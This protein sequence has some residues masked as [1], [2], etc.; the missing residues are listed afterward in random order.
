MSQIELTEA[1]QCL[2]DAGKV[3]M[4]GKHSEEIPES[5]RNMI[6]RGF[7]GNFGNKGLACTML[8]D[9]GIVL[10]ITEGDVSREVLRHEFIHAAQCHA[11]P[12]TMKSA[13]DAAIQVGQLL[14]SAIRA[15]LTAN[16]ECEKGHR[17]LAMA[18]QQWKM[19]ADGSATVAAFPVFQ[20]Y[21]DLYPTNETAELAS[22]ILGFDYP[23]G[24]YAAMTACLAA[25]CG[26]EIDPMSDLAR[27]LVA[28]TFEH[29]EHEII[30]ELMAEAG[31]SPDTQL[32]M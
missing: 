24:A 22:E 23:R 1:Q 13:L 9:D 2:V 28:Y 5:E 10:I 21:Q 27:E 25:E 17:D 11:S 30:D 31:Q 3:L 12:E 19:Q 18:E 4:I 32:R 15:K 16:P 7:A 6:W 14:V 20:F 26:Y 8:R 29:L